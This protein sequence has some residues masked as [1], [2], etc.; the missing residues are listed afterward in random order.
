M[1]PLNG[2]RP[3]KL[4]FFVLLVMG[5]VCMVSQVKKNNRIMDWFLR[6]FLFFKFFKF[7]F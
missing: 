2:I 1:N 5:I 4:F 7:Y 3:G 6:I